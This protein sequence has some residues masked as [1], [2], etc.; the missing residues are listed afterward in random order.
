MTTKHD[1]DD[2]HYS[3]QNTKKILCSTLLC[4]NKPCFGDVKTVIDIDTGKT[5]I[6]KEKLPTKCEIHKE[7][8]M[9]KYY[10]K[11]CKHESC[12]K[13]P[14]YNYKH[15][16][17]GIFCSDH[18]NDKMIAVNLK[19]EY[20]QFPD[21]IN[22]CCYGNNNEITHCETHKEENMKFTKYNI[23]EKCP[24]NA[25][26]GFPNQKKTRCNA[27]KLE[28]MFKHST[29]KC[30]ECK[31]IASYGTF[32][33]IMYCEKHKKEYEYMQIKNCKICNEL[34]IINYRNFCSE[35]NYDEDDD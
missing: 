32:N 13:T 11:Y 30:L 34:K 15:E 18:K 14:Q 12:L 5:L 25:L 22:K 17:S 27:H 8:N 28:N 26:Y 16:K 21:C 24:I 29:F 6:V 4:K 10:T 23:C 33:K 7:I 31:E 3:V 1:T 2:D 35:C 20:C 19:K 9:K